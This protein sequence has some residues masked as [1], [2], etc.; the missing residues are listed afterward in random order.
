MFGGAGFGQF[1]PGQGPMS[2]TL[3]TVAPMH[4]SVLDLIGTV[5]GPLDLFGSAVPVLIDMLAFYDPSLD[6]D[7]SGDS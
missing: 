4:V 7:A 2:G 3:P 1:Y 6:Q 5:G